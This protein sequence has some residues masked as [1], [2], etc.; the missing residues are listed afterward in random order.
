MCRIPLTFDKPLRIQNADLRPVKSYF[1]VLKVYKV[2][3]NLVERVWLRTLQT[4]WNSIWKNP[5]RS[6]FCRATF[7]STRRTNLIQSAPCSL[8]IK[9]TFTYPDHCCKTHKIL[10]DLLQVGNVIRNLVDDLECASKISVT[11]FEKISKI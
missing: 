6:D 4:I 7:H 5:Y 11:D 9:Q 2:I 1:E 8:D 10:T 3:Q